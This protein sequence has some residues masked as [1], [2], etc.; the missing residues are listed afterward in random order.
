MATWKKV[1]VSG[2][3]LNSSTDITNNHVGITD[4]TTTTDV[5]LGNNITFV[6]GTDLSVDVTD[7]NVTFAYNGSAEA[8]QNAFSKV[9]VSGQSDVE[10]ESTSDTLEF[11][12]EANVMAIVT[13]PLSD[14]IT[15]GIATG[16]ID[17]IKLADLAVETAKIDNGAVTFAKIAGGTYITSTET[18]ASNET[19][20][21]QFPTVKAVAD[22]VATEIAAITDSDTTYTLPV[23]NGTNAATITLTDSSSGTD[24]VTFTA[25]T[26][27]TVV[28]D[29]TAADIEIAVAT[30]G[31]GATQLNVSGNGTTGQMLTSAGDG[32]FS[33]VTPGGVA[34]AHSGITG[35]ADVN[36]SGVA[37]VQDITMDEYGHVTAIASTSIPNAA[38]NVITGLVTN[39]TQT[40]GGDKTFQNNVTVSGNLTVT[41]NTELQ[42]TTNTTIADR[43][44][45]LNQGGTAATA[46]I[47]FDGADSVFAW[48][49]GSGRFGFAYTGGD[50]TVA[51]GGYTN[52]GFFASNYSGVGAP[53]DTATL[54]QNGNIYTQTTGEIYI[55]S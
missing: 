55:Y 17:T 7:S 37:Y 21:N 44:I 42:S 39:S 6:G 36:N 30:N 46:G 35:A 33:W 54:A 26:A 31:I 49:Q 32:S 53:S 8:N 2:L 27:I 34:D 50:M 9:I 43:F 10:A 3:D 23:A 16:G 41:G 38:T 48:D 51:G 47:V 45:S 4:G 19:A 13:T 18:I 5:T 11:V 20:D 24:V 52:L 28:G 25:G 29:A 22:Y 1:L 40:F 12:A 14:A 15:F